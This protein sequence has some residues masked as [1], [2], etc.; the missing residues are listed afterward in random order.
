MHCAPV[1]R[2][3]LVWSR[4][5]FGFHEKAAGQYPAASRAQNCLLS[6]MPVRPGFRRLAFVSDARQSKLLFHERNK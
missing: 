6:K 4:E 5:K 3:V 2:G 1:R